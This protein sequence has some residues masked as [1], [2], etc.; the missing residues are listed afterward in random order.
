MSGQVAKGA[1]STAT[2][3]EAPSFEPLKVQRTFEVIVDMI[4]E[5]I[6]SGT[7][8]PGDRLPA[9]REFARVLR[10]GRPAVR[11]AYRALELIGILEIRKGKQG[12]AFIARQDH[13]LV[14]QSLGDLVRLKQVGMAQLTQARLVLE[15]DVAE[16]AL[17]RAGAAD[18]ARLRACI[19]EAIAQSRRGI[20]ATEENL[21]FHVLLGEA[22]GNPIL[23][24]MLASVMDLLRLV[25]RAASPGPRVSLDVAEDHHAIVDALEAGRFERLWPIME[26][27]IRRSNLALMKLA[28]R[29]AHISPRAADKAPRRRARAAAP[30][31]RTL[32]PE[33]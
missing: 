15:K 31:S 19:A 27:H 18:I 23:A 29:S 3:I 6:F 26:A 5:R 14:T 7:Y 13:R 1:R 22:S 20:T 33:A 4:K 21:R 11:E 25:I 30:R 16:L 8:E 32:H 2:G 28:G 9:E 10:V 24:I 12:G 17:H